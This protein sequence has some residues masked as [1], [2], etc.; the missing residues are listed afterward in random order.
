MKVIAT[1]RG[2]GKTT[3]LIKL[4]SLTTNVIVTHGNLIKPTLE[5]SVKLDFAIPR[6]I[7]YEEYLNIEYTSH[8]GYLI[9]NIELFI[10]AL[11]HTKR[12]KI[13]AISVS[14]D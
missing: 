7:S 12:I 2:H 1:K 14:I 6:P 5:L 8:T 9:D 3:D 13:N 11:N 4:S 10:E